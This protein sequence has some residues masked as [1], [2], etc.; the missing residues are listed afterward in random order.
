MDGN[1]GT[2][3][4]NLLEGFVKKVVDFIQ[5]DGRLWADTAIFVT[6]DE[7]GG[8]YDL[9]YIQTLDFF[10]DGTRI[11]MIVVSKYS[12]GGR[13]SHTYADHVST[14]TSNPDSRISGRRLSLVGRMDGVDVDDRLV[15]TERIGFA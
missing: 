4:V 9:G 5:G 15:R 6:F 12:T 14:L 7:G 1:P 11:P 3:K 2:S 8:F 10:G 13:I